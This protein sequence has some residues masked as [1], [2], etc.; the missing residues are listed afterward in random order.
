MCPAVDRT[1]SAERRVGRRYVAQNRSVQSRH[2]HLTIP[3]RL[4]TLL[5]TFLVLLDLTF[6][7]KICPYG[8][9]VATLLWD[10]GP[11]ES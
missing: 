8:G 3:D 9:K 10:R 2:V 7:L 11:G 6:A 4:G 5:L 1:K